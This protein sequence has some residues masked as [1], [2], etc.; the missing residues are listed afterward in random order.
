MSS[1]IPLSKVSKE[2]TRL[3][4]AVVPA[5]HLSTPVPLNVSGKHSLV[6][7]IASLPPVTVPIVLKDPEYEDYL[8]RKAEKIASTTRDLI[9]IHTRYVSSSFDPPRFPIITFYFHHSCCVLKLRGN[10]NQIS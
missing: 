1:E 7:K 6:I 9:F 4:G 3:T 2:L 8:Q 10:K 5:A